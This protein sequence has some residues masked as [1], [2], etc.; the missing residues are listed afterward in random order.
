MASSKDTGGPE[1][2]DMPAASFGSPVWEHFGFSV[3]YDDGGKKV[4]DKTVTA[5]TVQH[6]MII[7][8]ATLKI[9]LAHLW[10]QPLCNN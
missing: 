4:V 6:V 9:M 7:L 3:T 1:L 2:V 8:A 10:R 5:S